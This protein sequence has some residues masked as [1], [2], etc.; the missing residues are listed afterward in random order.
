MNQKNIFFLPRLQKTIFQ[1]A[2]TYL[3]FFVKQWLIM[4]LLEGYGKAVIAATRRA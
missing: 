4:W 1:I 3:T 2:C